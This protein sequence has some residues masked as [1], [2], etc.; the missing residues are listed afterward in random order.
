MDLN[1]LSCL[2]S[3]VTLVALFALPLAAFSPSSPDASIENTDIAFSNDYPKTGETVTINVTVHNIGGMVS[4]PVTVRFYT[5]QDIF[6]FSEKTISNIDANGTQVTSASWFATIP[7]AYSIKVKLNCTA[8]TNGANNEAQRTLTVTGTGTLDVKLKL[9]PVNCKPGQS[10][11][12]SGTVK[13]FNSQPVIGATVALLVKPSGASTS[14]TTDSNGEFSAN[15][16]SPTAAGNYEVE[17]S[18][19]SGNLKGND[20]KTIHVVMPDLVASDLVFSKATLTE[21]DTVTLTATIRNNGTDTAASIIVAFYYGSTRI[22]TKSVDSLGVDN[23]TTVSIGWKSVK[24]THEMKCTADPENRINESKEDNNA[25]TA[26]LTVKEKPGGVGDSM[27][28]II[29]L[30]VVIAV[31]G[32]AGL[33]LMKRRGKK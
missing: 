31:V 1:R 32:I 4:G 5:N 25:V 23:F 21:G 13:Q 11:I 7:M 10:F 15:L 30:V 16:T 22:G 14:A 12:A 18:A 27:V 29:V 26:S 3:A 8:D 24:G 17:A 6:P 28:M 2:L 33:M 20:T 9:D 19:S